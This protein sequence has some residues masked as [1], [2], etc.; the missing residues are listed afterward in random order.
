[1]DAK[2][3]KSVLLPKGWEIRHKSA[4]LDGDGKVSKFAQKHN[5]HVLDTRTDHVAGADT[6]NDA[7]EKAKKA[8]TY[9]HLDWD[10]TTKID[11]MKKGGS[12]KKKQ[13]KW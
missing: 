9:R 8:S 1:M 12:A 11:Y 2:Y 13:A 4:I 3:K 6:P 5:F 7:I 10:T